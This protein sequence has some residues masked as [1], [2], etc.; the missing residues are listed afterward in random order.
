[1]RLLALPLALLAL[2]L[3]AQTASGAKPMRSPAVGPETLTLD[4]SLYG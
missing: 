4:A 1:M 2:L 3:T